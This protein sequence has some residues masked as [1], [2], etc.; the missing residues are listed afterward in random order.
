[1]PPFIQVNS[2]VSG[3]TVNETVF[4]QNG[5]HHVSSQY[6]YGSSGYKVEGSEDVP[7]MD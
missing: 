7:G 6:L 3:G 5:H 4:T 2:F 1:M